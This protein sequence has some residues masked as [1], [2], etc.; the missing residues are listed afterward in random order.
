M[1]NVLPESPARFTDL[2]FHAIYRDIQRTTLQA[3]AA[4]Q[5][6][7]PLSRGLSSMTRPARLLLVT[8]ASASFGSRGQM[9]LQE[10]RWALR[11]IYYAAPCA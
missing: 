4:G 7:V 10:Q 3:A 6:A 1:D 8:M 9:L 2:P 5:R 11:T